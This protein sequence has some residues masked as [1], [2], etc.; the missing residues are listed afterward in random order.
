MHSFVWY[1]CRGEQPGQGVRLVLRGAVQKRVAVKMDDVHLAAPLH[2]PVSRHRRVQPPRQQPQQ[3]TARAN[4]QAAGPGRLLHV[5][6][7][8]PR[9]HLDVHDQLRVLQVHPR[10]VRLQHVGTEDAAD[11]LRPPRQLLERPPRRDA[12]AG[13]GAAVQGTAYRLLDRFQIVRR[14]PAAREIGDAEDLLQPL[15]KLRPRNASGRGQ[16]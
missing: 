14:C 15:L 13:E 4:G 3:R 9:D 7:G 5:D 10:G 16:Q 1:W 2:H 8:P 11:F 12:E 6:Q